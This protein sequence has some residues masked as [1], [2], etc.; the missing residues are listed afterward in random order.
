MYVPLRLVVRRNLII[1][2][3]QELL[4]QE[5]PYAHIKDNFQVMWR[6]A[7]G[8]LPKEPKFSENPSD[9]RLENFMWSLCMDCWRKDPEARPSMSE[10][11][12][13]IVK[14]IADD[15]HHAFCHGLF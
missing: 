12:P 5:R 14:G 13:T 9:K 11:K 8:E 2:I 10:L 15:M 1:D 4:A 3:K 6:I 7:A